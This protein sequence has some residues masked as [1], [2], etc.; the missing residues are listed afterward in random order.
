MLFS[1]EL[2]QPKHKH[3]QIQNKTIHISYAV[4]WNI[5]GSIHKGPDI[6][7]ISWWVIVTE[8]NSQAA[9]TKLSALF[10]KTTDWSS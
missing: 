3:S 9:L 2:V 8:F 7:W 5:G 4:S 1:F 6:V 10:M